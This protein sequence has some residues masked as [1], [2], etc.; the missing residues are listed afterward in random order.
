MKTAQSRFCK[1][2][3]SLIELSIV[4]VIIAILIGG[5]IQ[6]KALINNSRIA[7]ARSITSKATVS[8]VEGLVAWYET[9]AIDSLKA[10]EAFESAQI[11]TW[12]DISP[13]S[14][15]LKKNTL[16][17]TA[18]SALTYKAKAINNLPA[19]NFNGSANIVLSKFYQ[20]D[21]IQSTIFLVFRPKTINTTLLD[22]YSTSNTSAIAISASAVNLNAGSSVSTGTSNPANFQ[23][24]GNY[25]MAAHFFGSSSKVYV[26]N[27]TNPA[28]NSTID[29]GSNP[30]SGLT[31]GSNKSGG[32][33]FNGFIA[34]VIIFNRQL[35]AKERKDIFSYL[36]DKYKIPVSGF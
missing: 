8:S 25:I 6:G 17:R 32:N 15:T 33:G 21:F 29:A 10:S 7:N 30:L 34:E 24:D 18:S 9:S 19:L 28:G 22:S 36:S 3:F 20:G 14:I 5:T 16:N 23:V 2:A 13:A 4:I 26:N 27:I 11:S 1:K 31:I 12:Y 35:Q